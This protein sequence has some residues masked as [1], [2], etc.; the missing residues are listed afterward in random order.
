MR[1]LCLPSRRTIYFSTPLNL[2]LILCFDLTNIMWQKCHS[3]SPRDWSLRNLEAS[4]FTSDCKAVSLASWG[5]RR[6]VEG[7]QGA[8][9]GSWP[10]L[11]ER[12]WALYT[13][14]VSQI[15]V[16]TFVSPA[17]QQRNCQACRT[18]RKKKSL[19]LYASKFGGDLLH[20]NRSLIHLSWPHF[21]Y[22]WTE[23]AGVSRSH[24]IVILHSNQFTGCKSASK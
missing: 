3:M 5:M 16:V 23:G 17:N 14:P 18:I 6:S 9:V 19:L 15:Y 1:L 8:P 20:S 10:D 11:G 24:I 21:P 12:I 2:G 7:D 13:Q 22:L 4:A